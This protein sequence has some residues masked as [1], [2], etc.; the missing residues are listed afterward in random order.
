[1][2]ITVNIPATIDVVDGEGGAATATINAD[3]RQQPNAGGFFSA[4]VPVSAITAIAAPAAPTLGTATSG[5]LGAAN[6]VAK[7]TYVG[8]FGETLP[9]AES[10]QAVGANHVLTVA[11]PGALTGAT[12]YNVYVG[13]V[14]GQETKQNATPIPIGTNW[15][16]PDT[17]LVAG[18]A[19]PTSGALTSGPCTL[20]IT[21]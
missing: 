20:T 9:S 16:E 3:L 5:A 10:A 8:A 13:T 12:G 4:Q 17:G 21:Q 1:M 2:A 7:T 18:A 19:L 11:S 15:Q 14:T 6:L